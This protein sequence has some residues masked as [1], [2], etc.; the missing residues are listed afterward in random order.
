MTAIRSTACLSLAAAAAAA[1]LVDWLRLR[2]TA[3]YTV[4]ESH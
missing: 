3:D 4:Y 2:H 1:V